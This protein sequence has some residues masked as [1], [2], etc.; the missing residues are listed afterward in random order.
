M[1]KPPQATT[2]VKQATI[3]TETRT[4]PMSLNLTHTIKPHIG[5]QNVKP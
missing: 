1:K 5:Y 3:P 4:T 2:T